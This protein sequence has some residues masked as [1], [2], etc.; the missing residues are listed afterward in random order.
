M[1]FTEQTQIGVI[2]AN[3][4]A[5]SVLLKHVP[6]LESSP[7]LSFMKMRTLPQLAE[8]NQAYTWTPELLETILKELAEVQDEPIEVVELIPVQIMRRN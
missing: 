6:E 8:T 1:A 2:W 7:Y 3:R 4:T 5:R